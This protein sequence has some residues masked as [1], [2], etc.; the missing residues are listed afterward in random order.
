MAPRI[1]LL[2]S[3]AFLAACTTTPR[4]DVAS[5]PPVAAAPVPAEPAP[6]SSLVGEVK[7]PHEQFTLS[8]GLTVLVHEDHKAPVVGFGVWYNVGSKD[9]PKGKTGFAHL[10]EH[11]MF[12]G[13]DNVREPIMSYLSNLGATDWNGT[14]WFN[15]TNN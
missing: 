3:T 4:A 1:L 13:S 11:L 14:T 7:L 15:R 12:Y 9:E 8:N 2:A 5:A 10:F 6:L